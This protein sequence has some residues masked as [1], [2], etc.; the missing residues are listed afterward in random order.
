MNL[1]TVLLTTILFGGAAFLMGQAI[2]ETWRPWWQNV[3]YGLLLA[4]AA[5]FFG[6][7]IFDG[8]FIVASLVS[9]EAPPLGEAL[10]SYSI[11][12]VIVTALALLGYQL[13]RAR[14]MV[15]Q[16]PWLYERAGLLRWREKG[17]P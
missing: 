8:A 12:A 16:Y 14:K 11:D 13:T 1:G 2:A 3:A 15:A 10:I 6:Y 7:A 4:F 5:E 9:S 17:Q